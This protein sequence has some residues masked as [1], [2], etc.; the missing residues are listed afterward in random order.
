MA[1][2]L[3]VAAAVASGTRNQ[4]RERNQAATVW[5]GNLDEKVTEELLWELM[6]QAGPV[7]DVTM[8]A[9]KITG[10]H[11]NYAFCEFRS[12]IDAEYGMR[13]LNAVKLFGKPL[14]INRASRD[15]ESTDTGANLFVGNLDRDVDDQLLY[16]T[17]S[18]FGHVLDAKV[19]LDESGN[20]RGF[21]FVNFASFESSDA[22]LE[23]MNG[24]FLNNKTL[25]VSYAFKKDGS[26]G[27][28]HGAPSERALT[29]SKGNVGGAFKVHQFFSAGSQE[30]SAGGVG[31][32]AP[33]MMMNPTNNAFN[34]F[35]GWD[36]NMLAQ[37]YAAMGYAP[38]PSMNPQQ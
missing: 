23:T 4:W 35:A 11:Q 32:A 34:P 22:A 25:H 10:Q 21:G 30:A 12:E 29:A 7:L 14:R 18:A 36:Q 16:N 20:P 19:M 8:P 3:A 37:Y 28:R 33:V 5:I 9:D 6:I 26:K 38:P 2:D 17:F 13:I 1:Q 31:Q 27:E 15:K 24:Q